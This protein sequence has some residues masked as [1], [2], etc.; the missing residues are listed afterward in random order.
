MKEN[1]LI[2]I[3]I[4]SQFKITLSL[5]VYMASQYSKNLLTLKIQQTS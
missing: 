1:H 2:K 4:Y 5:S 3:N